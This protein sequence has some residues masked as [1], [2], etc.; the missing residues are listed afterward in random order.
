MNCTLFSSSEAEL[1][2]GTGD[3]PAYADGESKMSV[4][5]VPVGKVLELGASWNEIHVALGDHG[6]DHPLGFLRAGGRPLPTMQSGGDSGR[7]FTAA[8]TVQLLAWV[9]RLEDPRVR[10]LRQFLADAVLANHGII[11]H[12]FA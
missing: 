9:A 10:K 7:C 6:E 12:H 2:E 5:T 4:T 1:V 8:E 11:V 3:L